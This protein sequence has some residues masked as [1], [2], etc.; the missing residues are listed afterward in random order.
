MHFFWLHENGSW[1]GGL[2]IWLKTANV[3]YWLA[4]KQSKNWHAH[5]IKDK[6]SDHRIALYCRFES[7]SQR[8]SHVHTNIIVVTAPSIFNMMHWK[9]NSCFLICETV[10]A[11]LRHPYICTHG[12]AFNADM[13]G[14]I[15][16]I[17]CVITYCMHLHAS[18]YLP[19]R[20]LFALQTSFTWVLPNATF[21]GTYHVFWIGASE[22]RSW[23]KSGDLLLRRGGNSLPEGLDWFVEVP[24]TSWQLEGFKQ[25]NLDIAITTPSLF[26]GVDLPK[27]SDGRGKSPEDWTVGKL[28]LFFG[29]L[30]MK[31]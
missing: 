19:T 23:S 12:C 31:I 16:A 15:W 11:L 2:R 21:K 26:G 18:L 6:K 14:C 13:Y 5:S 30:Y 22:T 9:L 27:N 17:M 20:L 1:Q 3:S 28:Q 7:C 10:S 29:F 24:Q 8:L 4:Q 25:D